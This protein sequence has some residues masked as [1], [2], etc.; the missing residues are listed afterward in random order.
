M[1]KIGNESIPRRKARSE[2]RITVSGQ[3]SF[4]TQTPESLR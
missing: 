3:C 1:P 2:S 4:T